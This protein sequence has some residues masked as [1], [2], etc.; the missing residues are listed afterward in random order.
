MLNQTKNANQHKNTK[1]LIKILKI[2]NN[3]PNKNA[4]KSQ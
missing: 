2:I 1:N 4:K 3:N